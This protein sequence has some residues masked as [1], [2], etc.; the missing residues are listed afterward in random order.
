M[1]HYVLPDLN[2]LSIKKAPEAKIYS[3]K[4]AQKYMKNPKVWNKRKQNK[5][6]KESKIKTT[7]FNTSKPLQSLSAQGITRPYHL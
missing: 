1:Q 3:E 4:H 6:N 2:F 5:K 7:N